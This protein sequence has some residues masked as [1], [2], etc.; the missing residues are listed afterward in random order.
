MNRTAWIFVGLIITGGVLSLAAY[1]GMVA[2]F[3]TDD[4]STSNRSACLVVS[5]EK[6]QAI[7]D[8]LES[9]L[10][11]RNARAVRSD[12]Y[13]RVYMIAAQ[14]HGPGIDGEIGVWASNDHRNPGLIYAVDGIAREFSDWGTLP[15]SSAT[16]D[17][18]AEARRCAR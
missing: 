6:R 7:S 1:M 17:G 4:S 3:G 11:I 12:D 9:G 5:V 14:V 13:E 8:G 18:V 16:D 10:S 2:Y 15:D